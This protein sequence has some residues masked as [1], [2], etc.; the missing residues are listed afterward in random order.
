MRKST[1][2]TEQ[3]TARRKIILKLL[4]NKA[5]TGRLNEARNNLSSTVSPKRGV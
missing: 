1:A 2:R 4:I 5:E 3:R